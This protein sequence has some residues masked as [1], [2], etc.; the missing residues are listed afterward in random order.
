MDRYEPW[1]VPGPA[2]E[3][4][5]TKE[6]YLKK[7]AEKVALAKESNPNRSPAP[8]NPREFLKLKYI[9]DCK[10]GDC[11]LVP[12]AVLEAWAVQFE[13]LIRLVGSPAQQGG[14]SP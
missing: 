1:E 2:G 14:K 3:P 6:S 8:P 11:Q 7:V 9:G 4:Q 13:A 5:P 12:A 10:C